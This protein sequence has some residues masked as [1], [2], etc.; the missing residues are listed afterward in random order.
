MVF[1]LQATQSRQPGSVFLESLDHMCCLRRK[2]VQNLNCLGT[3]HF[4]A[5]GLTIVPF[6]SESCSK[7]PGKAHLDSHHSPVFC[8]P[9]YRTGAPAMVRGGLALPRGA[10]LA[11]LAS[12]IDEIDLSLLAVSFMELQKLGF[13]P[14]K[15]GMI[16][17]ARGLASSLAGV[18]W[19]SLADKSDRKNLIVLSMAVVGICTL[20][21]P[22]MATM[23]GLMLTQ[24]LSGLFASA[25]TPVSQSL[26]SE[27][28]QV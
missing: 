12:L 5:S 26:V 16:L 4:G 8:A 20:A 6:S 14:D 13:A 22:S 24:V 7:Q 27:S 25:V 1:S 2:I 17:M 10:V 18:F 23:R 11:T 21:T 3:T 28:V 15:L 9:A 19:G